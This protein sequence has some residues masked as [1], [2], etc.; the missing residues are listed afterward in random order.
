MFIAKELNALYQQ[1]ELQETCATFGDVNWNWLHTYN[2]LLE[3]Q[4]VFELSKLLV[5]K[6]RKMNKGKTFK[7]H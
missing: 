5:R 1:F 3:E 6:K 4:I 2:I 7:Q